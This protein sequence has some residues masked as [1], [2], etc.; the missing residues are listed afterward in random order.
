MKLLSSLLFY[1]TGHINLLTFSL[2]YA[3]IGYR[4]RPVGKE[5]YESSGKAAL[6]TAVG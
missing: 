3:N 5:R 2:L 6:I 4:L 1:L